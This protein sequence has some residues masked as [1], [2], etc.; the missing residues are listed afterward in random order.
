MEAMNHQ[1]LTVLLGPSAVGKGTVVARLM[2]LHPQ[3]FLSISATTRDPR[4]G[5]VDG[6]HY[7]F[8]SRERF[9]QL[10][11]EGAFLEWAEVHGMNYYGTLKAP[12]EEALSKGRPAL[13]EID[14]A[15]ARQV[16]KQV[17]DAQFIF[18]APPSWEELESRLRGRGS[19]TEEQMA[20]R[21]ETARVEIDAA[22]E[23]DHIV[24]NDEVDHTAAKLACLM[25][26][27]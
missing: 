13:L 8:L 12:I 9:L 16:R 3:I 7:H 4:P 5:E 23:F 20:R 26:L 22:N 6:Q 24:V 10:V 2:E 21:L 25:G 18:L 1:R 17:P 11:N 27:A 19:E 15:G 14:L